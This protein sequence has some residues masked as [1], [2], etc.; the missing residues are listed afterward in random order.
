MENQLVASK[1]KG[2]NVPTR[3][4]N[5]NV[6]PNRVDRITVP[7]VSITPVTLNWAD[8]NAALRTTVTFALLNLSLVLL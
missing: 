7:G 5:A 6:S 1:T 3:S 4:L 8:P 2:G